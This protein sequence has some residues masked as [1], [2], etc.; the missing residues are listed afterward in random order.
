MRSQLQP[1]RHYE[2]SLRSPLLIGA[3]FTAKRRAIRPLGANAQS[4]LPQSPLD[5]FSSKTFMETLTGKIPSVQQR[6]HDRGD[7]SLR[8]LGNRQ[9]TSR[10]APLD[11]CNQGTPHLRVNSRLKAGQ[12]FVA[13]C[14]V[15]DR[16]EHARPRV[17]Q[18]GRDTTGQPFQVSFER[19]RVRVLRF[20]RPLPASIE[21]KCLAGG[22]VTVNGRLRYAGTPGHLI[23]I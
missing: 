13:L 1:S 23:S 2:S 4:V 7:Q 18:P 3:S 12:F 21:Q 8:V 19:P 20:G 16:R 22:P 17:L 11:Y 14:R 10:P 6:P 15:D 9:L 5:D